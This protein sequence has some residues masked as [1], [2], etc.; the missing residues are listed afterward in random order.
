M[1]ANPLKCHGCKI[2]IFS[3]RS[4]S[5]ASKSQE[6]GEKALSFNQFAIS[7]CRWGNAIYVSGLLPQTLFFITEISKETE[8]SFE[9]VLDCF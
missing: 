1:N 7:F 9:N 6:H 4:G 8:A 2:F 5:D 3:A